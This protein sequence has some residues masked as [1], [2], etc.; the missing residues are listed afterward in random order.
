MDV[1]CLPDNTRVVVV[2]PDGSYTGHPLGVV[3]S[4]AEGIA[5]VVSPR[6]VRPAQAKDF[7]MEVE[8]IEEHPNASV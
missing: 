3:P 4:E 2:V 6:L 8:V 1:T 7:E 5:H